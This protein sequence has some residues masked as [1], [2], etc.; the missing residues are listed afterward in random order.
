MLYSNGR[1]RKPR[2]VSFL[3]VSLFLFFS[4]LSSAALGSE[5]MF[6]WVPNSEDNLAGYKI[7][8]GTDSLNYTTVVDVGNPT[9]ENGLVTIT[10]DCFSPGLIYYISATAYNDSGIESDYCPEVAWECPV[11]VPVNNAPVASATS[12]NTLE[13]ST[14]SGNLLATDADGDVLSYALVDG[15]SLGSVV[16]TNPATGAFV[17]TPQE[18]VFGSDKFTF[19]VNDGQLDS[20]IATVTVEI[21]E[22][23]DAPSAEDGFLVV[24]QG[25]TGAAVLVAGD[26]DGDT[27]TYTLVS[28]A[29][30]GKV[31]ID[32]N[33]GSYTYTPLV[34]AVGEDQFS[35]QVSDGQLLSNTATVKVSVVTV[36]P[37]FT[38]ELG[39]VLASCNWV[40]VAFDQDFIDPVVIAK[41]AGDSDADPCGIQIRNVDYSGFEIRL[42]NWDY[43]TYEHGSEMVGF[44]VLE[45]GSFVLPDGSLVEAGYFTTNKTTS[46]EGVGFA[47]PFNRVP[48]VVASSITVNEEAVVTGRLRDISISGFDFRMQEQELNLQEHDFEKIAYIAW[49]PGMGLVDDL[50]FK[51]GQTGDLVTH[52]WF[53]VDFAGNFVKPPVL[54]ADMQST[55][56]G[57]TANLRYDAL[58]I[59]G[60]KLKISEEQSKDSE[61][62]HTTENVGFMVFDRVDPSA[63]SDNDGLS[64]ADEFLLYHTN[65]AVADS[66]G[67]GLD[68]GAEVDYWKMDWDYDLDDDGLSNL[69]D[70]DADGDGYSDGV[71]FDAG[72]DLADPSSWP[73]CDS[74]LV[75][76]FGDLELDSEWQHVTFEKVFLNPVVV[77]RLASKNGSDPGVVRLKNIDATGFDLRIQEWDYLDGSHVLERATYVV[78]ESGSYTLDDG[79]M[80][81]VGYFESA[82]ASTYD[83]ID[84]KQ[85]FNV[86]PVVMTAIVTVN[87]EEAVCGRLRDIT[88]YGLE[89]KLQEQEVNRKAHVL[90]K[91]S[92]IAWE[93][94]SGNL[95]GVL[96]EVGMTADKVKHSNY[97]V[98]FSSD[99]SSDP[100]LLTDM[101][102][103]DG[104]DTSV[105]RCETVTSSGFEV[106]IEEEKSRDTEIKHTSE[107][108]GYVAF[109]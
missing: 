32:E 106:F 62:A 108:V 13:G 103:T 91:V 16:I 68:D 1:W 78:M 29:S 97:S 85:V 25:E 76:E 9:S 60:V 36:E 73:G 55:D 39:E 77:A 11:S 63:D 86:Q 44:V 47:Q 92:Y 40:R 59:S 57:D 79:T 4:F 67:D 109:Q 31:V 88:T 102:T 41:P 50:V 58:D 37:E 28:D 82:A 69:L 72:Y 52:A 95:D 22:V 21:E 105:T 61:V 46:Y 98:D 20:N 6:A 14:N 93:P 80:L 99:F 18:D 12:I 66:D 49:E 54:L 96:F 35:F 5:V 75:I 64:F 34:G 104:G 43:L 51:V 100:I 2:I 101:Q 90:E 42:R 38:V 30:L 65:P 107:V 84:F 70:W 8:Y 56:G 83:Q 81:E 23:N 27:L 71:E 3:L 94:S 87:E 24:N 45:R 48:V 17:Y 15:G 19:K 89:F 33:S 74:S 7:Y 10:M 26:N 53:A